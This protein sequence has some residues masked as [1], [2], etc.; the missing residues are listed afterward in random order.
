MKH[1]RHMYLWVHAIHVFPE[2]NDVKQESLGPFGITVEYIFR[3]PPSWAFKYK[4][5]ARLLAKQGL[6]CVIVTKKEAQAILRISVVTESSKK[7]VEV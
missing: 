6:A 4:K 5:Q 2:L 7:W 3:V 1:K